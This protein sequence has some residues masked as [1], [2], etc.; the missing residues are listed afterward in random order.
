MNGAVLGNSYV[1]SFEAHIGR[2]ARCALIDLNG[3]LNTLGSRSLDTSIIDFIFRLLGFEYLN[4][5]DLVQVQ[6]AENIEDNTPPQSKTITHSAPESVTV[7]QPTTG[8][9]EKMVPFKVRMAQQVSSSDKMMQN[10]QSD[11]PACN[12]CGHLTVRSGTC[13]KCLNCGNSLGC[14]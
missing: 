1:W 13:Y 4:R 3:W 6:P 14:S 5:N 7:D 8:S 2:T 10:M 9:G 11:A 12:V